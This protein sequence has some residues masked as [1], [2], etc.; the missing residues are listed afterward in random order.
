MT[1]M[2]DNLKFSIDK[3]KTDNRAVTIPKR[4]LLPFPKQTLVFTGLQYKS[5]ENT[6]SFPHSVFYPFG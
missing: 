1:D 4:F 6:F 5:F 3:Y 2:S